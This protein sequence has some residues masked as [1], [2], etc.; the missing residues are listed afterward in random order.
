[1]KTGAIYRLDFP[2]GKCYIGQTAISVERRYRQHT[3]CARLGND[4]AVYRAWRLY[5]A[6]VVSTLLTCAV[7]LLNDEEMRLI[8]EARS[9]GP[10]GYNMTEGGET[11]PMRSPLVA[12]KVGNAK[13][14]K[15]LTDAHR[16]AISRSQ[17]GRKLSPEHVAN[18]AASRRGWKMSEAQRLAMSRARTGVPNP[19]RRGIRLSPE[20]TERMKQ[21]LA[22][23]HAEKK[24]AGHLSR[25]ERAVLIMRERGINAV[26]AAKE[27]G[28]SRWALYNCQAYKA[29]RLEMGLAKGQNS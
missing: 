28:L 21:T 7:E 16:A 27:A 26:A 1:V 29:Y 18:Q 22:K 23:R 20:A 24:A 25:I 14:G 10:N 19:K 11:S 17:T 13:R 6:P 5:G 15:P 4:A 12:K 2:N 3:K 9:F 8:A